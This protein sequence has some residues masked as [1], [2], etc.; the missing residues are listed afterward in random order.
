M[1][2]ATTDYNSIYS[3]IKQ[4]KWKEIKTLLKSSNGIHYARQVKKHGRKS[5]LKQPSKLIYPLHDILDHC[6]WYEGSMTKEECIIDVIKLLVNHCPQSLQAP[7]NE[8]DLP[9]HSISF[10]VAT[11]PEE[12]EDKIEMFNFFATKHPAALSMK[13]KDG[14]LPMHT[15][16]NECSQSALKIIANL[17]QE[18]PECVKLRDT[19]GDL[20]IHILVANSENSCD[21]RMLKLLLKLFPGSIKCQNNY[22]R[23]PL[24]CALLSWEGNSG[25]RN[26]GL[27]IIKHLIGAYPEGLTVAENTRSALPIDCFVARNDLFKSNRDEKIRVFELLANECPK[28]L[29]AKNKD[30]DIPINLFAFNCDAKVSKSIKKLL[31]KYPDVICCKDKGGDLPLHL[32]MA[33]EVHFDFDLVQFLLQKHPESIKIHDKSW[34]LPIHIAIK[35]SKVPD[36]VIKWLFKKHPDCAKSQN[37]KYRLPID[38]ARAAGRSKIVQLLLEVDQ[39]APAAAVAPPTVAAAARPSCS[40][41]EQLQEKLE[42]ARLQE[43]ERNVSH[44]KKLKEMQDEID[45]LKQKSSSTEQRFGILKILHVKGTELLSN[46]LIFNDAENL[47][48]IAKLMKDRLDTLKAIVAPTSKRSTSQ[49]VLG[50]WLK[51]RTVPERDELIDCI[52]NVQYELVQVEKKF[53]DNTIDDHRNVVA[54]S[55]VAGLGKTCFDDGNNGGMLGGDVSMAGTRDD[56]GTATFKPDEVYSDGIDHSVFDCLPVAKRVR[57]EGPG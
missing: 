46:A 8:G 12:D 3:L 25:S 6:T 23:L 37:A 55:S 17:L 20:L 28:S 4:K 2:E 47:K 10:V 49:C 56:D 13:D 44:R 35:N 38:E 26:R 18:N 15:L 50:H 9:I 11:T 48:L 34:D 16:A 21:L 19:D 53:F 27:E 41:I 14:M 51:D 7:D 45:F 52:K 30:G 33:S 29:T 43:R 1:E 24:H 32:V 54:L 40:K 31:A 36:R 39:T 5:K 42:A 22:G 57:R